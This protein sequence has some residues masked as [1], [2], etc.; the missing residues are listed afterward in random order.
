M[1]SALSP[2]VVSDGP[3]YRYSSIFTLQGHFYLAELNQC[4]GKCH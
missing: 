1:L 4:T 3:C 2:G